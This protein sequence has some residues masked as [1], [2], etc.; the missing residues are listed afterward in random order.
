MTS[1]VRKSPEAFTA[2]FVASTR[3]YVF[4]RPEDWPSQT[5]HLQNHPSLLLADMTITPDDHFVVKRP[6]DLPATL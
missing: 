3:D 5:L 6:D 2:E 1:A 4:V